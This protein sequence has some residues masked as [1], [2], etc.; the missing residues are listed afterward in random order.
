MLTLKILDQIEKERKLLVS[1]LF[2][3]M[4]D[5]GGENDIFLHSLS[6]FHIYKY[7]RRIKKVN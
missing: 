1:F 5:N 7:I 2:L 6:H 3:V 4:N